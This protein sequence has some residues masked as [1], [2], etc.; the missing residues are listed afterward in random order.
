M[1]FKFKIITSLN[2]VIIV[3]TIQKVGMHEYVMKLSVFFQME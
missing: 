1:L 3:I 2:I